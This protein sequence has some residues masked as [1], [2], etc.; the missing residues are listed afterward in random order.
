MKV[1]KDLLHKVVKNTRLSYDE[2]ITVLIKIETM[3]NFRLLTYLSEDDNTEAITPF[4]L[5]HGRDNCCRLRN[6]F[7]PYQCK[8]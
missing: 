8:H 7:N 2:L 4:H 5:L 3:I 1:V 6:E